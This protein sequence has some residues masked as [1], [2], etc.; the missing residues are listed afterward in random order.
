METVYAADIA[1]R[2]IA[3]GRPAEALDW[4]KKS[5]RPLDDEETTDIDLEVVALEALGEKDK[6]QD[7]RWRYSPLLLAAAKPD[8]WIAVPKA[9]QALAA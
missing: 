2:L 6:A 3:A 9:S 8:T 5:R 4:L 7:A 1:K